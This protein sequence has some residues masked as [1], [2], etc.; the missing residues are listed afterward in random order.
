[1]FVTTCGFAIERNNKS[2]ETTSYKDT[3]Y[4]KEIQKARNFY[5]EGEFDKAEECINQVLS[6]SMDNEKANELRNKILLLKER[7]NFYK[8]TFVNDYLIELRRTVKEGNCYEGFL[9]IKRIKDLAPEENVKTFYNRLSGEKDLILYSLESSS[10]KKKFA[11]SI[12][13]FVEEKFTDATKMV[14]SLYE[15]YPKFVDYVG[16]CRYYTIRETNSKRIKIL[17]S[18]AVKYFKATKLGEAR[19]Y[20]EMCYSL[21]PTNLKLK[22]LIDQINMEII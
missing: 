16:L 10:D 15:K 3:P 14:Y 6:K 9:Y 18:K 22:I 8:R 2:E 21:E 13:L 4:S 5:C 7:E 20:A 1:M 11:E 12:D 19:N 17:Y